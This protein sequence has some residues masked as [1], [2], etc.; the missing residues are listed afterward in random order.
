MSIKGFSV[1]GNVERYDYNALDNI[2]SEITIDTALSG[3]STN[4][5]QNKVVTGAINATTDSIAALSGEVSDLKSALN[6][7]NSAIAYKGWS[8]M[9]GNIYPTLI[10]PLTYGSTVSF[11]WSGA[12]TRAFLLFKQNG[13]ATYEIPVPSSLRLDVPNNSNLWVDLTTKSLVVDSSWH[14]DSTHIFLGRNYFGRL[15]GGIFTNEFRSVLLSKECLPSF[16]SIRNEIKLNNMFQNDVVLAVGQ[17][18]TFTVDSNANITLS[19]NA[20]IFVSEKLNN[21]AIYNFSNLSG[22]Y[23]A[24]PST[25]CVI[26][27]T[28]ASIQIL[29]TTQLFESTDKLAILFFNHYGYPKFGWERYF[30]LQ[31]TSEKLNDSITPFSYSGEK[32]SVKPTVRYKELGIVSKAYTQGG[33]C[34]GNYLFQFHAQ[35]AVE[36]GNFHGCTVVNL[37]TGKELQFINLGYDLNKHNNNASFGTLKYDA[38]DSF[39]ALYASEEGANARNI[40]VYR[41]METGNASAPFEL[42]AIQ[43]INVPTSQTWNVTYP[44]ACVGDDGFIYIIGYISNNTYEILKFNAPALTNETVQLNIEDVITRANIVINTNAQGFFVNGGKLYISAGNSTFSIM[45]VNSLTDGSKLSEVTFSN[46]GLSNEPEA[47]FLFKDIIC[48]TFAYRGGGR[49]IRFDF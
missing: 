22:S 16:A 8:L 41:V 39:P 46:I 40:Q 42:T 1:G 44:N 27:M 6:E 31:Q 26:N 9:F 32:I 15:M 3:S 14:Y 25:Y 30:L 43:T 5:V 7:A 28:T 23:V 34:Y 17:Q 33:A 13:T 36:D 11:L 47:L 29:T 21:S 35:N 18:P 12:S 20:N 4:P 37:V 48:C 24:P 49:I 2:P 19:F 38:N 10:E 45:Q